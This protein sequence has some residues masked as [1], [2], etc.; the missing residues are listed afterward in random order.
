MEH[1]E[2]KGNP[3]QAPT[4]TRKTRHRQDREL[5]GLVIFVLV[6]GGTALIG[7]I[8]G[9]QSALLGFVCLLG[10]AILIGGLWLLLSLLEKL[11]SE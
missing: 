5:L 10:G 6:G 9:L 11:V 7:L 2:Q 4:N 1:P 8:W 3:K